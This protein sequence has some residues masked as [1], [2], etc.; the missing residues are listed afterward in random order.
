MGISSDRI[1]PNR[2]KCLLD[3]L[4]MNTHENRMYCNIFFIKLTCRISSITTDKCNNV[5]SNLDVTIGC[6][7]FVYNS[8]DVE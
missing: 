7:L 8:I 3:V 2:T 5:S 6:V 4:I 1:R